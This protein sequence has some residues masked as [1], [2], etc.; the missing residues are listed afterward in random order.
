[1]FKRLAVYAFILSFGLIVSMQLVQPTSA[2][3]FSG[4]NWTAEYFAN[5]NFT[6]PAALTR[7]DQVIAFNFGAGAPPGTPLPP[8]NFSIR[9]TSQQ[10]FAAGTY[11][12]NAFA[13]DD[14][15]VRLNGVEIIS[16]RNQDVNGPQTF[17]A[18]VPV[19]AGVSTIQVEFVAR[20]GN[21]SISFQ[22][23]L[24]GPP[25]TVAPTPTRT[26]TPLPPIPP[27]ALTATVIRAS[28]LNVRDAPSLGGNRVGRILRG[29]TYQVVG[30]DERARWFLLELGGRQAWAW[31]YYLFINGNEFNAPVRSPFGTLGVPPGVVDTGVVAQTQSTMRLRAEPNVAS[32][33]TGRITWGAFL[34]VVGRTADG[35]WYQVVWRGTVGWMYSPYSRIIQGDINSVPVR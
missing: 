22:W 32:A 30:R 12:F 6:P 17:Q 11:T 31:G 5:P 9:W 8:D 24:S 20:T 29:E 3:V 33:Q 10:T 14:V 19:D 18:T 26:R 4:S 15:R 16:F 13:E 25:G 7:V 35:F 28:V 21:A 2:Q 27:G 1:M 34:P 23:Q